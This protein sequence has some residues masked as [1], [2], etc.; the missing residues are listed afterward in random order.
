MSE[1][2][3]NDLSL[4]L[5]AERTKLGDENGIAGFPA[6]CA[7]RSGICG[8]IFGSSLSSNGSLSRLVEHDGLKTVVGRG[9]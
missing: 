1:E 5:G 3:V 2:C 6:T 9:D 4:A 8:L 7:R